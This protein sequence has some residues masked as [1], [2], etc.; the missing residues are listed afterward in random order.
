MPNS[1]LSNPKAAE[2]YKKMTET[3]VPKLLVQLAIPTVITM[4]ISSIY[5][6]VDTAFVGLLG[7]SQSAA[8]G[9]VL[10]F[11]TLAQ[12]FALMLGQ[13]AGSMMS[14]R[15][16]AKEMEEAS[17]V[18][19]TGFFVCMMFS[20]LVLAIGL[21]LKGHLVYWL[22]ST[23]TIA[24][25]A[26][27]YLTYILLGLPFSMGGF[28]LNNQLRFEGK[29]FLGM[30]GIFSG[31]ILNIVLDPIFIFSLHMGI[32]GAGLAT[33][34]SQLIS[35]AILISMFLRGK[36]NLNLSLKNVNL[37][38]EILGGILGTGAPTL[39]RQGLASLGTA[40]LN[41]A[42]KPYGDEAVAAM[43]IVAKIGMFLF[44]FGLGVGQG[45]QPMFSYNYGARIYSRVR[46]TFKAGEIGAIS[47]MSLISIL[48]FIFAGPVI[49]LFRNDPAVIE[50]GIR[51]LRL[52][53]ISMCFVPFGM[54]VEMLFQSTG[55]KLQ[56]SILSAC[57]GGLLFIPSLL[58]LSQLRGLAGIQEAQPLA[59]ILSVIPAGIFI[60]L[61]FKQLPK[62]DQL[63]L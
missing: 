38:W 2:Q 14:R 50:I 45:A 22:G 16:G 36:S 26:E 51:A 3:P 7:T 53:C 18:S 25:Y 47:I 5:N 28:V 41:W 8:I 48:V 20:L 19:S 54:I 31:S 52:L 24:P 63:G 39:I 6:L 35:F 29:A 56:A 43:T 32:R 62:E 34:L 58:I 49:Q 44:C 30:I 10:S 17:M 13:G 61:Y 21:P 11:M 1:D 9:V 55:K 59:Y 37:H 40:I 12:A 57:R 42:A 15:L 23:D 46:Q 4:L 27:Q 60:V 33:A